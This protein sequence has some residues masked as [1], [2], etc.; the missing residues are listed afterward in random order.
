VYA[1][2]V[3]ADQALIHGSRFGAPGT[4]PT[5]CAL[6][7]WREAGGKAGSAARERLRDGG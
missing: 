5:D 7:H 3:K 4:A 2:Q 6:E 1:G